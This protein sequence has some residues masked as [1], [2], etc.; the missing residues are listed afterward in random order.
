MRQLYQGVLQIAVGCFHLVERQNWRGA[1]NKLDAGTRRLEA[2]GVQ[3]IFVNEMGVYG[4]DWRA[5]IADSDRLQTHL[6]ELGEDRVAAAELLRLPVV[7]YDYL[8]SH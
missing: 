7:R 8:D 2:T 3:E 5:L 6:R 1:V 4:V